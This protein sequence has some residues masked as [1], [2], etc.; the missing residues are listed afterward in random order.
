MVT[1]LTNIIDKDL[2]PRIRIGKRDTENIRLLITHVLE[3]MSFG[4]GGT[5]S[6]PGTDNQEIDERQV[7]RVKDAIRFIALLLENKI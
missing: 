1:P 6:K 2:V 7:E 5:F 4:A 3:D